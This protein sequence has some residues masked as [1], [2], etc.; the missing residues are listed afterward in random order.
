MVLYTWKNIK[1]VPKINDLV[2]NIIKPKNIEKL[3]Y[4]VL[5]I[6]KT[7]YNK[8]VPNEAKETKK[9]KM[10]NVEIPIIK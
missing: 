9:V 4:Q 3:Y 7:L 5:D 1:E 8:N 2:N 6:T 10:E